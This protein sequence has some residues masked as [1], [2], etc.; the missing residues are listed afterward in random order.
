[1]PAVIEI[2][3]A[4]NEKLPMS[5]KM[6]IDNCGFMIGNSYTNVKKALTALD[7][8]LPVV[9]EAKRENRELI[10]SHHPL[11]FH[12]AKTLTDETA[13]GIVIQSVI[14]NGLAVISMHT[15][16]D[17]AEGGLNDLLAAKIGLKNIKPLQSLL[18]R[19]GEIPGEMSVTGFLHYLKETL[20]PFNGARYV[21][22]GLPVKRLAIA[23]G[24]C[25]DLLSDAVKAGCDTFITADIKYSVMLDAATYGINLIDAGH[26]ETEKVICRE[27][28]NIVKSAFPDV[29]IKTADSNRDPIEFFM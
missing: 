27:F 5:Y 9:E 19:C 6:D 28:C 7:V 1:M 29:D 3:N 21:D 15:N 18:G 20:A 25:D 4:L 10:I 26:F 23:G 11:M 14:K 16:A 13:S 17:C 8:T 2:F 12:P 22:A 24:A